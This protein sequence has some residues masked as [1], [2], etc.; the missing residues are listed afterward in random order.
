[1]GAGKLSGEKRFHTTVILHTRQ[2]K[3]VVI[4]I[5]GSSG[6]ERATAAGLAKEGVKIVVAAHCAKER[7]ETVRLISKAE[8]Y[9]DLC[10]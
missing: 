10:R 8:S 4:I 1:V 7:E 9:G 2:I 6:I 5:G 3:K